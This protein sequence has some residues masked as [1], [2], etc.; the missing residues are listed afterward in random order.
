MLG[1]WGILASRLGSRPVGVKTSEHTRGEFRAQQ[2]IGIPTGLNL[3][4]GPSGPRC[5]WRAAHARRG[6]KFETKSD[7]KTT[8]GRWLAKV[9]CTL[10]ASSAA[11]HPHGG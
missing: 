4:E 10:A 2:H 7:L 9:A 3:R 11:S 8:Q 6:S 5:E 1:A